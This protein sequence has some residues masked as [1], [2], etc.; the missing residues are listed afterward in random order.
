MIVAQSAD[1]FRPYLLTGERVLW[2][3]Q[4]KQGFAFSGRDAFLIPFSL[5]WGGFAIFWNAMVW[6]IPDTGNGN[7]DW[8]FRLWGLPF[9]V[10]GLYLI[11]GRF[12]HDSSIRRRLS[13]AVTDQ[14]VLVLRSGRSPKFTSLDLHR[15]PRLELSEHR[16]GTGT[17][18]FDAGYPFLSSGRGS[19]Y[20]VPALGS[21]TQFFRIADPRKVYEL[22]RNQYQ[23]HAPAPASAW[24]VRPG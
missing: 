16:D 6:L 3:G 23:P 20:W 1:R 2:S 21:A 24:A 5:L 13:Y 9:L 10:I 7:P 14:R 11:F 15:L 22:I 19:G 8:F 4:P 12:I 17:I 18:S